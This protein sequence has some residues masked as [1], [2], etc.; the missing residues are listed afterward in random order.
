[1]NKKAAVRFSL[2]NDRFSCTVEKKFAGQTETGTT[3]KDVALIQGIVDDHL[4]QD[5]GRKD[6]ERC[7]V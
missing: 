4:G 2:L 6:A 1:M 7:R 5:P 3:Q